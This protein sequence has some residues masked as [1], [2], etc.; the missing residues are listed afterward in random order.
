MEEVSVGDFPRGGVEEW[1]D[2]P[3]FGG[4]LGDGVFEGSKNAEKGLCELRGGGGVPGLKEHEEGA[5]EVVIVFSIFEL[6]DIG[7]LE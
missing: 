3:S 4:G 5:S 1:A 7:G 2:V 6:G